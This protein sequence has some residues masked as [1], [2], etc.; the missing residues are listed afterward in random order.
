MAESDGARA[1]QG[2]DL[3]W[4]TLQEVPDFLAEALPALSIEGIS[5]PL[6]SQN[7]YHVVRLADQ[8]SG[9]QRQQQE[10]LAR[11]IFITGNDTSTEQQLAGIGQRIKSGESFVAMAAQFSQDPNSANAGGE[12]PWFAEG[13]MPAELETAAENVA[14]GQL[15]QPFR[16]Q[17]GWHI[18]EVLER[19]IREVSTAA[20]RQR[21]E[22]S[23][24]QR[25]IE[26]ESE[27]WIRQLRD[28]S[29]I[30]IRS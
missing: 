10:T 14:I 22:Q 23:L 6:R 21:A 17:F 4:R 18:L 9:N 3:G 24:R 28:E 11:H 26:Q 7:G 16:T 1:L 15:T 2:G 29:F 20:L 12:L 25:K 30:D 13:Q 8:R 19:R 5:E 27:R